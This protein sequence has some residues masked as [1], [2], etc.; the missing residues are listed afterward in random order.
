MAVYFPNQSDQRKLLSDLDPVIARIYD[1]YP[2]TLC[3]GTGTTAFNV[4]VV[5]A[6]VITLLPLLIFGSLAYMYYSI[7][8]QQFSSQ[9]M[10]LQMMLFWS[11]AYQNAAV[12]VLMIIP[13]FLYVIAPLM[14]LRGNPTIS[15]YCFFFFL[16]HT[17]VDCIM[18]LYWIKPYRN[19]LI[20]HIPLVNKYMSNTSTYSMA[21]KSMM[22]RRMTEFT[23][24]T[25]INPG[26]VKRHSYF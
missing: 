18:I 15:V 14:G 25:Y 5:A 20:R 11:F 1:K 13:G 16:I 6:V 17:P 19:Y 22:T 4:L 10:R 2:S 3:F 26:I 9:T 8:K 7:K 21:K 12:F 24:V 23:A